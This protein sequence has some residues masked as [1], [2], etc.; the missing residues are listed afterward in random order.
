MKPSSRTAVLVLS[1]AFCGAAAFGAAHNLGTPPPATPVRERVEP[2]H[3]ASLGSPK[4]VFHASAASTTPDTA[5]PIAAPTAATLPERVG[6]NPQ[7]YRDGSYTGPAMDAYYGLLRV[8]IDVRGGR[9]TAIHVLQ[10]PSDNPTS[11]YINSQA[12]PML[13]SEVI[14]AQNVFVYMVSGATLS[15]NAFLRSTYSALRQARA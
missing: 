9:I 7:A 1:A 4:P 3:P 12:L 8:R 2:S 14:Q 13:E 15:S 11:R 6:A 5:A 10:Y